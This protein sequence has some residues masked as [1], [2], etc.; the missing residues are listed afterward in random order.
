MIPLV[1][2]YAPR[3]HDNLRR[4][5]RRARYRISPHQCHQW[6]A[7]AGLSSSNQLIGG[8]NERYRGG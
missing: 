4:V 6:F 7:H 2:K 5:A 8:V 3:S 1:R